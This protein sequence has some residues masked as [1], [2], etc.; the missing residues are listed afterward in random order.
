MPGLL[1]HAI[2]H[3]AGIQDRDGGISLL[4]TLFGQFPFL[5]RMFADSAYAGCIFDTALTKIL[6]NLKTEI[7]KRSDQAKGCGHCPQRWIVERTIAWLNRCRR[8]AKDWENLNRNALA[9]LKLASIRFMLRKS[10]ILDKVSG[11][12]LTG[13]DATRPDNSGLGP[14]VGDDASPPALTMLGPSVGDDGTAS[15]FRLK[16]D[17]QRV[18]TT[19]FGLPLYHFKYIGAPETYEGVMAQDVLQVMPGAVSAGADG[20]YRVN[21]GA[22]GT[23]M[24]QVS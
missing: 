24:R 9:F 6:P 12:T 16:E 14:S 5:K 10:A 8:L 22:L 11:R 17:V 19:V 21:Y 13:S 18:G 4:A 1:P 20:H 3:S 7:V 2:I 23:S 15:D